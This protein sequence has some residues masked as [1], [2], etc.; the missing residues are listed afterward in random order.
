MNKRQRK[1]LGIR[2]VEVD[3]LY[4]F[5]WEF[6]R[7]R[8]DELYLMS[9]VKESRVQADIISALKNYRVQGFPVDA[10]GRR[11]RGVLI[12]S[13]SAAGVP[14]GALANVKTGGAIPKGFADLESTLAPDGRSLYIEV[15][16]PMW[17]DVSM[18]VIRQAGF[19]SQEQLDFL[20]EKHKRG[21]V[22]MIA[23]SA[24]EVVEFL[25]PLLVA[26]RK[27]LMNG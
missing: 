14:F 6:R 11:A 8:Y 23:W 13:A 9:C 12:A 1:K 26:N 7:E 24:K 10:G 5:P 16:A 27:A 2:E 19:A 4:P 20:L 21:A 15:K 25:G 22:V 3:P 18:H 17:C